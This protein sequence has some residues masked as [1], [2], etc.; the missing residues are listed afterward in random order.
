V[1][2]ITIRSLINVG[3]GINVQGGSFKAKI[4]KRTG[5]NK[6]TGTKLK[7]KL[8]SVHEVINVHGLRKGSNAFSKHN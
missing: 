8:I 4:N 7:R 3:E 6:R 5:Y 1:K 2:L